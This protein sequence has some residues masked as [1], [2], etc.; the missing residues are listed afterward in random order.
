MLPSFKGFDRKFGVGIM[1]G[2]DHDQVNL[3]VG[4]EVFRALIMSGFR[5]VYCAMLSAFYSSLGSFGALQERM[6]SKVLVGKD[7]GQVEAFR[8]ESISHQ[9]YIYWHHDRMAVLGERIEERY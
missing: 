6:D 9:S 5:V 3:W 4:E 8:R 7:K 2:T 1:P